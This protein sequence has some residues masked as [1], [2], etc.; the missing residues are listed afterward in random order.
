MRWVGLLVALVV[1]CTP[2]TIS[3]EGVIDFEAY[4]TVFLEPILV[5]GRDLRLNDGTSLRDYLSD[6]LDAESGFKRVV[7]D[8]LDARVVLQVSLSASESRPDEAPEWDV[9]AS[10]SLRAAEGLLTQGEVSDDSKS[11]D[12]AL[13]DTLD[14]IALHFLRPYRL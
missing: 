9:S 8:P 4:P 7:R 11:L 6:E 3:H 5:D 2:L 13:T 12:E 14:E 10:F 1:G